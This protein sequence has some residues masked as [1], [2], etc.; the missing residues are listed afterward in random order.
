MKVS[1]MKIPSLVMHQVR[2]VEYKNVFSNPELNRRRRRNDT[3]LK[4]IESHG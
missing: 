4:G 1:V 3:S 2:V